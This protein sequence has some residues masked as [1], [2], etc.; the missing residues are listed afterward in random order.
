MVYGK[1]VHDW[2]AASDKKK[3]SALDVKWMKDAEGFIHYKDGR[4]VGFWTT[5]R[6]AIEN[7]GKW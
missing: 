3:E 5:D 2:Q 1:K 7:G 6:T 4:V